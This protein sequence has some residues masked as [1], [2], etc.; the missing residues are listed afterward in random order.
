MISKIPVFGYYPQEVKIEKT[1]K[2]LL[3]VQ[4]GGF[5]E[6]ACPKFPV[7]YLL[8]QNGQFTL[9]PCHRRWFVRK[10]FGVYP[11]KFKIEKFS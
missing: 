8:C 2:K 6:T 4:K 7:P 1:L 5:Q 9:H 10:I 11:N 3:P